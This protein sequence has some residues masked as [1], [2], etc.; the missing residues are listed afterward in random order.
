EFLEAEIL[1]TVSDARL[2]FRILVAMNAL[3][4]LERVPLEQGFNEQENLLLSELLQEPTTQTSQS[5]EQALLE[6]NRALSARI[7]TGSVPL[8]THQ[9]LKVIA[10]NKLKIASPSY[11][12]RYTS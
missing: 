5:L 4:M 2:K 1:P 6:Q 11:L 8:G 10:I 12:K 9:A 3:S 7:R